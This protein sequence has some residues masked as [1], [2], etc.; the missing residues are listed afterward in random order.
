[1]CRADERH[2][3]QRVGPD[4]LWES[5][6]RFRIPRLSARRRL[7]HRAP[8]PHRCPRPAAGRSPPALSMRRNDLLASV[9][10]PAWI[11]PRTTGCAPVRDCALRATRP[12]YRWLREQ[13]RRRSGP[14]S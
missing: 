13:S 12:R 4:R 9:T 8:P 3:P 1:L 7:A 14:G 11:S 10:P 5:P 2:L 6:Q